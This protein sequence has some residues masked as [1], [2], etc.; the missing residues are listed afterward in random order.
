MPNGLKPVDTL[1]SLSSVSSAYCG[2]GQPGTC[3]YWILDL[4]TQ[5]RC[6]CSGWRCFL[7]ACFLSS[8]CSVIDMS[9]KTNI[10]CLEPETCSVL[11]TLGGGCVSEMVCWGDHWE[12]EEQLGTEHC[13]SIVCCKTFLISGDCF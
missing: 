1:D 7:S 12:C 11:T 5:A 6:R 9:F 2:G 4:G 8:G 10:L 13:T 3:K